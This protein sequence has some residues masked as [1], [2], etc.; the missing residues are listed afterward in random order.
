MQVITNRAS[1]FPRAD[2]LVSGCFNILHAGHVDLLEFASRYGEVTVGINGEEYMKKKY[3]EYAMPLLSRSKVLKA[4][5]YVNDVVF[6]NE[7]EP[8]ELIKRLR[9]RYFV[10]GPDYS[11]IVLTESAALEAV[12]STLIIHQDTKIHDGSNII[13]GLEPDFF[14]SFAP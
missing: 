2:V 5:R 1:M 11:G 8:S 9:P 14:N 13:K 12:G 3:G 7:D 4:C 6:F 10:R